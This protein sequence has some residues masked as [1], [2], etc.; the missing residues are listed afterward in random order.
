MRAVVDDAVEERLALDALAH[1]PALHVRDGDDD[2]VDLAVADHLLELDEARVLAGR[3]RRGR[4]RASDS[5]RKGAD[6]SRASSSRWGRR[7]RTRRVEARRRVATRR[8]RRGGSRTRRS[9]STRRRITPVVA[10]HGEVE[11]WKS[12]RSAGSSVVAR[13]V[14]RRAAIASRSE[15]G[16]PSPMTEHRPVARTFWQ[17]PAG[18]TNVSGSVSMGN[19]VTGS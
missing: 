10:V 17:K 11:R 1:E 14:A 6:L 16:S 18:W 8:P 15:Q 2:R 3:G 19:A 12:G 7:R 5:L 4:G 9:V 13:M